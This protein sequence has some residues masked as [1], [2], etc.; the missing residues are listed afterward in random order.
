MADDGKVLHFKLNK[1]QTA[2]KQLQYQF[3]GDLF[4]TVQALI[5]H[6]LS[7]GQPISTSSNAVISRPKSDRSQSS[8]SSTGS[9]GG[10]SGSGVGSV[11][12]KSGSRASLLK[13]SPKENNGQTQQCQLKR[14]KSLPA[15]KVRRRIKRRAPSPPKD[16]KPLTQNRNEPTE[17]CTGGKL[18]SNQGD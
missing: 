2:S 8:M 18:A 16:Q 1:V 10:C 9:S 4:P 15:G 7:T 5:Y 11:L 12:T 14:F 6:H 17:N 13:D 3:E